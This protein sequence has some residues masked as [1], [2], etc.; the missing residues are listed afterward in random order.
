MMRPTIGSELMEKFESP[1]GSDA[2]APLNSR[3]TAMVMNVTGS[4]M[5]TTTSSV[6]IAADSVG[7]PYRDTIRRCIG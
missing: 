3:T 6:D 7:R 5:N 4:R 2:A 1:V